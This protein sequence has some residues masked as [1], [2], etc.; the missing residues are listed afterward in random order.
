MRWRLPLRLSRQGHAANATGAL[1]PACG[2][3]AAIGRNPDDVPIDD[4]SS[5]LRYAP[6]LAFESYTDDR[7]ERVLRAW[8]TGL[9][10]VASDRF[11]DSCAT[12][13]INHFTNRKVEGARE[14]NWA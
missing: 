11:G 5:D 13:H 12:H 4:E 9:P 2:W 8:L 7:G 14:F 6:I 10:P 3:F 1:I